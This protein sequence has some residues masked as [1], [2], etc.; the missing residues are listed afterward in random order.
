MWLQAARL[1]GEALADMPPFEV[2]L[3]KFGHFKHAKSATLFLE[4]E[5]NPPGKILHPA[6]RHH[7]H[8]LTVCA[9]AV[10]VVGRRVCGTEWNG[11]GSRRTSDELI[12]GA[13][14]QRPQ[15]AVVGGL[16]VSL[17]GEHLHPDVHRGVGGEV[18]AHE[19]RQRGGRLRKQLD[20]VL[21]ASAAR[22]G[23]PKPGLAHEQTL[24]PPCPAG[25]AN[26]IRQSAGQ[27]SECSLCERGPT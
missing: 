6:Q 18:S 26:N 5:F 9:R 11:S 24:A 15:T 13:Q 1:L 23:Q 20:P 17:A 12:S 19:G 10:M 2:R 27:Q 4:P 16:S 21:E 22:R 8:H 3:A 25:L 14:R 7:H